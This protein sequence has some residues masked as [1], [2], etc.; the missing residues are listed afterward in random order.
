MAYLVD[1]I[2]VGITL[3]VGVAMYGQG[4]WGAGIMFVNIL[5]GGIVAFNFY[6]P[7][8]AFL[9]GNVWDFAG[10]VD[11]LCLGGIFTLT[12]L[13]LRLSTDYLSP[14]MVKFPPLLDFV[15]RVFFGLAA[16]A[17]TVGILITFFET[18]PVGKKVFGVIGPDSRAPFNI[19][20]DH[21][22]LNT[23]EHLT[24]PSKH[25]ALSRNGRGIFFFPD[26]WLR[27]EQEARP[28]PDTSAAPTQ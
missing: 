5:F 8:A 23:F 19:G 9:V 28:Y 16:G 12:V 22:W 2:L 3:G 10:Y 24:K 6:E 17:L 26:P 20:L 18:A 15:G 25:G 11:C 27:N 7:L 21:V 14:Q 13:L 1:A 4:M